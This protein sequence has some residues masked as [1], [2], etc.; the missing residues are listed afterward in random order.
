MKFQNKGIILII[1]FLFAT[2]LFSCGDDSDVV[3]PEKYFI[4]LI[5]EE[6][7]IEFDDQ[8]SIGA[9][10]SQSGPQYS[11]YLFGSEEDI[12]GITIQILSDNPITTGIYSGFSE[13]ASFS[14]GV[15]IHLLMDSTTSPPMPKTPLVQ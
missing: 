11:L 7:I 15:Y 1:F 14:V 4:R 13:L 2:F 3:K 12:S 10:F 9:I 6:N 8:G 5:I